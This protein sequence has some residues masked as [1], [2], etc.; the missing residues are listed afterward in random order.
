MTRP[1]VLRANG[2]SMCRVHGTFEGYCLLYLMY[3]VSYGTT[4]QPG[5]P[6]PAGIAE[7]SSVNISVYPAFHALFSRLQVRSSRDLDKLL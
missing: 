6:V 4:L 3:P 1:Q 5:R 2:Y 7:Y